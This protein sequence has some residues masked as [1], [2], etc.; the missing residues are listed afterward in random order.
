MSLGTRLTITLL[1]AVA[2][3]A[4]AGDPDP[5]EIV[6][7]SR[8]TTQLEGAEMLAKLTILNAK[9]QKRER[10]LAMVSKSYEGG[11]TEKRLIRFVAPAD[12]KGTGLLTYD[13][14]T[15]TDD[16]WL[17]MPALRKTR[18]IVASDKAKSFMGSEFTYADVTPPSVQDFTYVLLGSEVVGGTDCWI[19]EATPKTEDIA[20][21][22]GYSKR[23]TWIGK[24][25]YVFRRTQYYDLS[26]ELLKELTVHKVEKVDPK[27]NRYRPMHMTM[28]N[29]QNGRSSEMEFS[30]LR[31]RPDVPDEYFTARYLERQ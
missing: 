18:R 4:H 9:K 16:M 8:D 6:E 22:N 25:D 20:E 3:T 30:Q 13:Y 27:N 15:K 11:E 12:V 23:K 19:V 10:T 14:E 7:K 31:L 21:E 24:S 26:G 2:S 28:E 5:I 1:T 29:K 17:F